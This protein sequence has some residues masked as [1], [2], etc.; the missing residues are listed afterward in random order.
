M[1]SKVL[2]S[3]LF[4]I[5]APFV[6]FDSGSAFAQ[7]AVVAQSAEYELEFEG[8]WVLPAS[9]PSSA[10]FT[11]IVGATHNSAA[12][13]YA[14]GQQAT[15]GVE[16]VA[17]LGS[18]ASLVSEINAGIAAGNV[19]TA[20]LGADTFITPTEVDTFSFT[21]NA[22][23]PRLTFLTM[24]APSPDWFV[25][26]SD[27]GLLDTS[28]QWRDQIVIDLVSY[29][30]GTENGTGFSLS[31]PASSP[32]GVITDL[33]TA[34][35]NGVL[36]GVGSLARLTLTRVTPLLGDANLDSTVNFLDI[37]S[38]IVLLTT[39]AFQA[40]ADIDQNGVVDFLDISPFVAILSG[41]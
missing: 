28:G 26:V 23:H 41:S 22:S 40:E 21:A 20:I 7:E 19:D 6:F 15:R 3:V 24:V 34:E 33:D 16:R 18:T 5:V 39:G 35:P 29:D 31:N 12:S 25:G 8:R 36:F 13:L 17:E 14:V 1:K 11:Q 10:H 9:L 32:Q 37:S 2:S 30:A 38:F 27:L 4:A